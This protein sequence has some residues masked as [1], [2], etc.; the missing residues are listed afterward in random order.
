MENQNLEQVATSYS[1]SKIPWV[2]LALEVL[3]PPVFIYF[4]FNF[5]IKCIPVVGLCPPVE[6]TGLN[7]LVSS[8]IMLYVYGILIVFSTI[9]SILKMVKYGKKTPMRFWLL[10]VMPLILLVLFFTVLSPMFFL[11]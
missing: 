11:K 8:P 5:V 7:W 1:V 4:A 6:E 10:L 9:Y 3:S 2:L